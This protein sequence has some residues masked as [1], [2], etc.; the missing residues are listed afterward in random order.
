VGNGLPNMDYSV[1]NYFRDTLVISMYNPLQSG[2][3]LGN[4]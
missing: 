2:F 3:G 1:V 4:Y